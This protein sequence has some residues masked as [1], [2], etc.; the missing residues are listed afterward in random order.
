MRI[1]PENFGNSRREKKKCLLE[2]VREYGI[3]P[4]GSF[5]AIHRASSENGEEYD[6]CI[7]GK[8]RFV[9]EIEK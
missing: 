9:V 5:H 3:D 1:D 8:E 4:E 6:I 2:K 7:A